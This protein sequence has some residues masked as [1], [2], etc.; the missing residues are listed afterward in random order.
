M[1]NAKI[2]MLTIYF[3][4]KVRQ[5]FMLK[6]FRYPLTF[7]CL[8]GLMGCD[9]FA[10]PESAMDEY[11]VRLA[12]VLDVDAQKTAPAEAVRYPAR[13]VRVLEAPEVDINFLEFLSLHRCDVQVLVG[14]R[15]AILGRVMQPIT[16]LRYELRFIEAAQRCIDSRNNEATVLLLTKAIQAKQQALPV[17][18]WN[19]T[20]GSDE[21]AQM[22]RQSAGLYPIEGGTGLVEQL[23]AD[24]QQLTEWMRSLPEAP[25]TEL[26][27][28][29]EIQQ[30]WQYG[31]RA[32]QLLNSARLITARLD[33]GSAM[34]AQRID[35]KPLCP[36]GRP[37]TAARTMQSLF[38]KVYIATVQPYLS[39]IDRSR[40][41]LFD[42]LSQM[43]ELQK[44]TMPAG[45]EPFYQ[46]ALSD[47]DDSVWSQFVQSVQ[48]H[49][50]KWQALLEQCGMRPQASAF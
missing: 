19:T 18:L 6:Y 10:Q 45:F 9:P 22:L 1:L 30:R 47:T 36:Q 5:I 37:T 7:I 42:E 11:I 26:T 3:V 35:D 27:T 31:H 12:R 23:A 4:Q 44:Q 39:E 14:E 49:T 2:R 28:L 32:G 29:S 43:A 46:S 8:A 17:H 38:M 21:M 33:D 41:L 15:N 13:R 34:L 50:E 20:W 25:D 16:R 24:L 40:Q 48:R